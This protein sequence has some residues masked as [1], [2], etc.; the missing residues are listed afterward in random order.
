MPRMQSRPLLYCIRSPN[1]PLFLSS[2]LPSL[3]RSAAKETM[4][5]TFS[6]VG[7]VP[8]WRMIL[9]IWVFYWTRWL[10][11]SL[12]HAT[13]VTTETIRAWLIE[14]GRLKDPDASQQTSINRWITIKPADP[15]N[16][17]EVPATCSF[18]IL[19]PFNN[20]PFKHNETVCEIDFEMSWCRQRCLCRW[21]IVCLEWKSHQLLRGHS[22]TLTLARE[23]SFIIHTLNIITGLWCVS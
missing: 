17:N 20:I 6:T 21:L 16:L 18:V 5:L 15:L 19:W 22:F 12:A 3:L 10:T 7:H 14:S 2:S 23:C 4:L 13:S 9:F 8:A 11:L 1:D